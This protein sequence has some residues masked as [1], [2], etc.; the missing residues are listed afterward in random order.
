MDRRACCEGIASQGRGLEA[1]FMELLS[2]SG[3]AHPDHDALSTQWCLCDITHV[4]RATLVRFTPH[5]GD[6]LLKWRAQWP[7]TY[8]E[9]HFATDAYNRPADLDI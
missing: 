5:V 2:P 8:M 7:R 6:G 9:R 1:D 3:D 4:H